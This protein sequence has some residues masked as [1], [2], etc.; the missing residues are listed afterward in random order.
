MMQP[1]TGINVG[2]LAVRATTV[3]DWREYSSLQANIL[4]D[5][6]FHSRNNATGTW[7]LNHLN[8]RHHLGAGHAI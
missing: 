1:C 5:R 3:S 7:S 4:S 8:G 6:G 2:F